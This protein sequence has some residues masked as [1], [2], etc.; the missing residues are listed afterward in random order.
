MWR[1][2]MWSQMM[3][4]FSLSM[5]V[6]FILVE[7]V[8]RTL[9]EWKHEG[10]GPDKAMT[11]SWVKSW[12][13]TFLEPHNKLLCCVGF[14]FSESVNV[15]KT[16]TTIDRYLVIIHCILI[17]PLIFV[18]LK[19]FCYVLLICLWHGRAIWVS[20]DSSQVWEFMVDMW[21]TGK[22]K[23]RIRHLTPCGHS[24]DPKA[25]HSMWA[26]FRSHSLCTCEQQLASSQ[27]LTQP[28]WHSHSFVTTVDSLCVSRKDL[29]NV[30]LPQISDHSQTSLMTLSKYNLVNQWVYG[31]YLQ[32]HGWEITHRSK[33][34]SKAAISSNSPPQQDS[35][36]IK[37][38]FLLGISGS[39]R[40][41][42]HNY[43]STAW[44][45]C[46]SLSSNSLLICRL[47]KRLLNTVISA[48]SNL[49]SCLIPKSHGAL[50][51]LQK[52]LFQ[53]TGK[54]YTI[55]LWTIFIVLILK[56]LNVFCMC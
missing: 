32:E 1:E 11:R 42:V 25:S 5:K 28:C 27:S 47:G 16:V 40:G 55:Y 13:P 43:L 38:A 53:L 17:G 29:A 2:H 50:S 30:H 12:P 56:L 14:C 49:W 31:C 26:L 8:V 34:D 19:E 44:L 24:S 23:R 7:P 22:Q 10:Q 20:R 18:Q 52:R 4:P 39:S 37:A 35:D 46:V 21:E 9:K 48:F 54:C 3:A 6:I 51:T 45:V 15:S 41:L 36:P 33:K